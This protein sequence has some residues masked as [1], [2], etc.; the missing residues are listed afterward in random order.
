MDAVVMHL[1]ESKFFDLAPH[2][3]TIFIIG[4]PGITDQILS[5]GFRLT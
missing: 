2:P 3:N 5:P 4:S 1:D